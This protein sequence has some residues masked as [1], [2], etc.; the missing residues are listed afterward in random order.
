M[1]LQFARSFASA[2]YASR[3]QRTVKGITYDTDRDPWL[4]EKTDYFGTSWTLRRTRRGAFYIHE[5]RAYVD[6]K[7][8]PF[9]VE[10]TAFNPAAIVH[11]PNPRLTDRYEE[12]H[13]IRPL[14]ARQ[15]LA[16]A[17]RTQMPRTFHKQ[18]AHFLT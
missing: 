7:P 18:L 6:G 12:R 5:M 2:R 17:I 9:G 4:A 10:L 8:K 16:W 15:A 13:F 1:A 11:D 3:M 14:T